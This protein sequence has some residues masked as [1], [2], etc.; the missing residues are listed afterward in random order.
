MGNLIT[1]ARLPAYLDDK[2]MFKLDGKMISMEPLISVVICTRNRCDQLR[3]VLETAATMLIPVGLTWELILVDNGSTDATREVAECFQNVL[4]IK[5]VEELQL[6]LSH[7]RNRGMLEARGAYICWTDDDVVI[8][9]NWLCAYA[10]AFADFPD[11][12]VFG[13]RIDPQIEGVL[14]DWWVSHGSTLE[15]LLGKRHPGDVYRVITGHDD[16]M[17]YGANFALR[18][19]DIG[20]L[21]FDPQLGVG[22]DRR[23]LGEESTIMLAILSQGAKGIWVPTATVGNPVPSVRLSKDYVAEYH[24]G[25]GETDAYLYATGF[26][27]GKPRSFWKVVTRAFKIGFAIPFH[28]CRYHLLRVCHPAHAWVPAWI[29]YNVRKGM[30]AYFSRSL[31]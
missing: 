19:R 2:G 4:P 15:A 10:Q 26:L 29:D 23:R 16:D 9:P 14:P 13:G 11:V 31:R 3:Q 17:P 6:G 30:F 22:P 18:K 25:N 21:R 27:Q 5:V 20:D 8:S 7:A 1:V 28:Y 12:A 24:Q